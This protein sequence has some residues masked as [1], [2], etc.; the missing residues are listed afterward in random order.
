MLIKPIISMLIT[1]SAV[2][3]S[4]ADLTMPFVI[5]SSSYFL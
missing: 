1:K 4:L 5:N 2:L 3:K